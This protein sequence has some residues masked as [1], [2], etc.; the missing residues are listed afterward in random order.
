MIDFA[1]HKGGCVGGLPELW[2]AK[3]KLRPSAIRKLALWIRLEEAPDV[4]VLDAIFAI[5]VVKCTALASRARKQPIALEVGGLWL[6]PEKVGRVVWGTFPQA[7]Q[8]RASV[9]VGRR[10]SVQE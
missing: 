1:P 7:L 8:N 9:G 5:E 10:G 6:A 4:E 3:V 2:V